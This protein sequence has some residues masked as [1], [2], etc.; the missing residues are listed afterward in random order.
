MWAEIRQLHEMPQ[1][2]VLIWNCWT[3]SLMQ[4]GLSL[5]DISLHPWFECYFLECDIPSVFLPNAYNQE[6]V[7]SNSSRI[8]HRRS[9]TT[10]T[11]AYLYACSDS[12]SGLT[13]HLQCRSRITTTE[14]SSLLLMV[15]LLP[16]LYYKH[17]PLQ[18]CNIELAWIELLKWQ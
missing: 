13:W 1:N 16:I 4:A 18:K 14:D 15:I 8:C 11:A 9:D 10:F 5:H 2:L 6:R 17:P 7:F 12:L 3:V